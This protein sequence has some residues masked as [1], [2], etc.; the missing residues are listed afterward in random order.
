M[1]TQKT[2]AKL[3][4]YITLTQLKSYLDSIFR[5]V[6]DNLTMSLVAHR[7]TYIGHTRLAEDN[8]NGHKCHLWYVLQDDDDVHSMFDDSLKQGIGSGRTNESNGS[9]K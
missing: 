9:Y 6:N 5:F 8:E 3:E 1:P 7:V 2:F 4:F